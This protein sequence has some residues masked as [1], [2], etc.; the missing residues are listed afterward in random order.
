MSVLLNYPVLQPLREEC[1]EN[2]KDN[3]IKMKTIDFLF[4]VCHVYDI[5]RQTDNLSKT[6]QHKEN[7]P[8]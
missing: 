2:T 1:F 5:L 6:L 4:G 3:E 7:S 8:P